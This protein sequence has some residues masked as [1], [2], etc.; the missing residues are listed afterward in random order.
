MLKTSRRTA[1]ARLLGIGGALLV[2]SRPALAA[3]Q[4]GL[5][6]KALAA[7]A[8]RD[9][10]A[11][12]V[13]ADDELKKELTKETFEVVSSDLAPRFRLGHTARFL[14][15]L[16]QRGRDVYLWKVSFKDKSDDGL[17][18]MAVYAGR[19]TGFWIH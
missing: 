19:I 2:P 13:H 12:I 7:V 11:F 9:H 16:K 18:R 4:E 15:Q 3:P 1:V 5:F 8:S 17:I 14:G 10:A 6:R